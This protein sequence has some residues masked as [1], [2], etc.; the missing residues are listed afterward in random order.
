MHLHIVLVFSPIGDK[1]R[2]RI[3]DVIIFRLVPESDQLLFFGLVRYLA[4]R[5]YF[6]SGQ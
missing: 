2:T 1:L 5:G 6:I 3:R 4:S